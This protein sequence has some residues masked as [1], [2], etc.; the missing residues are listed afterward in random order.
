MTL[1]KRFEQEMINIYTTAKKECGYNASRFLQLVSTKGGLA[2]AKQLIGKPGGTE[3]FTTLWQHNRLD[4]SVEAHVL[5]PEYAELF[6]DEER[7]LCRDRLKEFG[8]MRPLG[9]PTTHS[10]HWWP[11]AIWTGT[12][13]WHPGT[14][15]LLSKMPIPS[16]VAQM[17]I[18][19]SSLR[20][21]FQRQ[22]RRL[23]R[24]NT[25][26]G[27][28]RQYTA[29]FKHPSTPPLYLYLYYVNDPDKLF[30][31]EEYHYKNHK[32]IL[33]LPVIFLP[34]ILAGVALVLLGVDLPGF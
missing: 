19:D 29:Y 13:T 32:G 7:K 21:L 24:Y 16:L 10:S 27:E 12:T 17:T 1:E 3:G 20:R 25:I 8:Y 5:K 28:E 6:S 31:C 22:R 33:L 23:S 26:N 14:V 11:S 18:F 34:W 4:L 15:R 30:S 9:L 2:A